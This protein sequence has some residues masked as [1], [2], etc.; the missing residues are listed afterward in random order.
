M[1][2]EYTA[3]VLDILLLEVSD[4]I[5]ASVPVDPTKPETGGGENSGPMDDWE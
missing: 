3:P 5:T 2:K 1:K 4:I